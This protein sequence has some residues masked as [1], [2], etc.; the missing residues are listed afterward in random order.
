MRY[1]SLSNTD[2]N[3]I[4]QKIS[5]KSVDEIYLQQNG[6][7][8]K[9]FNLPNH[10]N[11]QNTLEYIQS[12]AEQNTVFKNI[13][14]GYGCYNHFIPA[15]VDAII[16]RGEFLTSYTPYQPEV[17]QGT[18][19]V[20]FEFQS[21]ICAIT[22]MEVSNASLYDGQTACAEAALMALR[23][24]KNRTKV[25]VAGEFHPDYTKVL[26]TYLKNIDVEISY[27][28]LNNIQINNEY[29][30]IITQFPDFTGNVNN[31]ENVRQICNENDAMMV[32]INNEILAF[33]MIEPPKADII[34]GDA[35]SLG[36]PLSF[37][38]PLLGYFTCKKEHVRQMPGR[39]CGVTQDEDGKRSF[40]L[41]LSAREQHIRRDKA[42][43]N[44][45]SNQGLCAT[46]FTVHATLL[47]EIGFKNL[48]LQ[49][50]AIACKLYDNLI[51]S[52]FNVKN[53]TFFNEFVFE[54]KGAKKSL[55]KFEEN[56]IL[57]GVLYKENEILVCA[58]EM[59]SDESIQKYIE[60]LKT[61]D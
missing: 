29:A 41:T 48:A 13:F 24:K 35:S 56:G 37:G 17:S 19:Q 44:I 9:S 57:G 20:I 2:R 46:A 51:S 22:N 38:G 14:A 12:F 36:V 6:I 18:L 11:E 27:Q 33:G 4:M 34:C 5:I 26:E 32:V 45:C 31:L 16:Q 15:A 21:L 61:H 43:S 42:T 52:G 3:A 49:N 23:I 7:L 40:V 47:G 10:K 59:I 50:H 58:T 8:A 53:K 25:C 39:V 1:S 30:C 60:V 54:C 28:Q 55:E